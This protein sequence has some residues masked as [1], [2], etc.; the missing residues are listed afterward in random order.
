MIDLIENI[1]NRKFVQKLFLELSKLPFGSLPKIELELVILH[2]IIEAN[3]GYEKLNEI[4]P[5]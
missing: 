3:G 5:C 4:T 1:D 2:S